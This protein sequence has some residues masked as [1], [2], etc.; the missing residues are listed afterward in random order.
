ME[1]FSAQSYVSGLD[2][3]REDCQSSSSVSTKQLSIF[4]QMS[5]KSE[6]Q[7]KAKLDNVI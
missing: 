5:A 3:K 2:S 6:S 1:Q 7:Q 4:D